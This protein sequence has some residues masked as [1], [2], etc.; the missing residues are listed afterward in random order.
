MVMRGGI[1]KGSACM[2]LENKYGLMHRDHI[3]KKFNAV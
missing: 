3:K 2:K 1:Q